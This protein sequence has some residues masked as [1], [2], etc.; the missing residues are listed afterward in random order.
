MT[1]KLVLAF[2]G[3][4]LG[5]FASHQRSIL[6]ENANII[7]EHIRDVEKFSDVL[8][9]YWLSQPADLDEEL[10]AA[11]KVR[12]YH[13]ALTTFYG[14]AEKRL[15]LKRIRDYQLIQMRLYKVGLGGDFETDGRL[16]DAAAAIESYELISQLVH[17]L[18]LARKEQYSVAGGLVRIWSA[19]RK[20]V[21]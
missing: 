1:E 18:R 3:V 4:V 5:W 9:S 19:L 21:P 11:A 15:S 7:S 14:E 17:V 12:A 10:I 16:F 2:I 20:K 13:A 6:S 8:Q